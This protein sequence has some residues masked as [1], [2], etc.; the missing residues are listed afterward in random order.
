MFQESDRVQ[1]RHFL[2]VGQLFLQAYPLL[3]SA[4]SATQSVADGGSRPDNSAEL[5]IKALVVDLQTIETQ[6]KK[7]WNRAIAV[8]VDEV[9]VDAG[10]AVTILRMEGRRLA[11]ALARYLG[12]DAV[13]ADAFGSV[14]GRA[15]ALY[16]GPDQYS[17]R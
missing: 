11:Y 17:A 1:I 8:T 4:I 12:F 13:I 5:A 10:R 2:G 3:E 14:G 7:Q 15:Q 6:L 16:P 9:K